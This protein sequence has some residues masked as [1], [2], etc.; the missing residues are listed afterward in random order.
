MFLGGLSIIVGALFGLA[1]KTRLFG[2]I[3]G[4][5]TA[6]FAGLAVLYHFFYL[7]PNMEQG[8]SDDGARIGF[9]FTLAFVGVVWLATLFAFCIGSLIN[10]LLR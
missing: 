9:A 1:G 10:A 6:V 8:G 3:F 2:F 4:S 5:V 7:V